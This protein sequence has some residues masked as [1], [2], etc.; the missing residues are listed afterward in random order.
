MYVPNTN[1]MQ[2][3]TISYVSDISRVSRLYLDYARRLVRAIG[4]RHISEAVMAAH[5]GY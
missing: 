5:T 4:S 1:N 2:Q 3:N